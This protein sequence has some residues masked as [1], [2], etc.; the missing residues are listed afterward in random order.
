MIIGSFMIVLF[1]KGG[2][3]CD[4]QKSAKGFVGWNV[5]GSCRSMEFVRFF[6]YRG[7]KE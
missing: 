3:H 1:M 6:D 4:F 5:D 7:R 2:H